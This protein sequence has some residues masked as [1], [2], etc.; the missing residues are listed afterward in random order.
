MKTRIILSTLAILTVLGVNAQTANNFFKAS[1]SPVNPKVPISWNRYYDS[2]G[3]N[4]LE[5]K[6][7]AA[8]PDL[9]R[10]ETIGQSF[11]GKD[12]ILMTITDFSKGNPDDKPGFYIDG[13][14]H[15]NEIQGAEVSLYIA[16]YLAES[17]VD[18]EFI[19]ELLAEKVFYIMPSINPDARDNYMK[20]GNTAHSPRA[21]MMPI[22]DDRDGLQDEDGYDDLDGDGHITSMWRKNKN[23]RWKKDPNDSRLMVRVKADEIGDYENLGSEGLD[24]DGDGRVNEDRVGGY[25]D[26]NRDWGWSW[27]PN[28]IQGGTYKYSFSVPENKVVMEFVLKHPNIAGAQSFH[29]SGGMIL[30]G[31]GAEEDLGTYDR[32]DNR[33]YD[34]LGEL[35]DRVLPGYSYM[36]VYKDLYSVFGG[37]LDWFHGG[38]GVFTFTNELYT[39]F[40]MFNKEEREDDDRSV[41]DKRLLM[42][43]GYIKLKEYDHPDYGKIEIGGTKKNFGRADP[44]FLLESDAHRNMAFTIYHAYQTPKLVIEEIDEKDLGGGLTQVTVTV[45]NKRI[46]PTHSSHD[47]KNK[48]E[49]PDY[50]SIKGAKVISGMRVINQDLN[51]TDEQVYMPG[52]LEVDN[53]PGMSTVKVRW[54]ISGKAKYS[55][56]VNSAKGGV[57]T[58]N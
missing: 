5:G 44:G 38:R 33:V 48:I 26:P 18:N 28:H 16:W 40:M 34:V 2:E 39:S 17:F 27:Q 7:A 3:L 36:V 56:E 4:T 11:L 35:G 43:D 19:R 53:I 13:N 20:A 52:K 21:G 47:L 41:F 54:L 55:I 22:D 32:N 50:I 8:H 45:A 49:R 31:P 25:Y 6:L 14:I 9:V 10:I 29:N 51:L 15:S 42:E 23:G 30:R 58:S 24:N 46:I 37:E 57:H 12:M 1:G